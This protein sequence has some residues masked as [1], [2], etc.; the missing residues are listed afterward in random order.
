VR[1]AVQGGEVDG[2]VDLTRHRL[3]ERQVADAAGLQR[4]ELT[5]RLVPHGPVLELQEPQPHEDPGVR[6]GL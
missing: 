1:V 2:D 4:V 6:C 5:V 3:V